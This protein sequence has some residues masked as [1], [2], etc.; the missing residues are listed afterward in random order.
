M[1]SSSASSYSLRQKMGEHHERSLQQEMIMGIYQPVTHVVDKADIDLDQRTIEGR[2]A[3]GTSEGTDQAQKVFEK[4]AYSKPYAYLTLSPALTAIVPVGTNVTG[5]TANGV[6]IRGTTYEMDAQVGDTP[7]LVRY[8]SENNQ[9]CLVGG[10]PN[11]NT[12]GC[13]A[14]SGT[15]SIGGGP[16]HSYSYRPLEDNYNGRNFQKWSIEAKKKMY[17]CDTGCPFAT[18]NKFYQYYNSFDYANQWVT[19][20]FAGNS[21]SFANGNADF[22]K[23]G[24]E[25]RAAAIR[26]GNVYMNVWMHVIKKMQGGINIC[27]TTCSPGSCSND[28][29]HEFDQA[30]AYYTGS[31]PLANAKVD[32]YM[33]YALAQVECKKFGTCLNNG[34]ARANFQIYSLLEEGKNYLLQGNCTGAKLQKERITALMAIPLVQGTLRTAYALDVQYNRQETT[35]GQAAAFA[36]AVLPILHACSA[37]RALQVYIDLAVGSGNSVS[38]EVIKDAL[39]KTYDCLQISCHDVGGL[40]DPVGNG[41]YLKGA[42]PCDFTGP[43]SASTGSSQYNVPTGTQSTGSS[44][45]SSSST[46]STSSSSGGSA[47]SASHKRTDGGDANVG[48]AVGLT[49]GLAAFIVVVVMLVTR[50]KNQVE[51]DTAVDGTVAEELEMSGPVSA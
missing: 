17:S 44:Q 23:L 14:E 38:Y 39:E 45:S 19:A 21:T 12:T 27:E 1:A 40:L 3:L 51:F 13:F 7:L 49:L 22:S 31:E 30:A 6:E 34:M 5:Q 33:L 15:I 10:N 16:P 4:G 8:S 35:Q 43:T 41:L 18:Y 50:S 11:P 42:A 28:T 29:A 9:Q 26:Y 24:L 25:G 36:A 2:L 47:V 46:T 48:L 32:G 20:A 37:P